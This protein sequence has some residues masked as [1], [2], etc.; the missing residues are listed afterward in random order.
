MNNLD[1]TKANLRR[2]AIPQT[3]DTAGM[4]RLRAATLRMSKA[5]AE[6]LLAEETG[7][8]KYDY[9]ALGI[10]HHPAETN[11]Q[12]EH[13]SIRATLVV[14]GIAVACLLGALAAMG[15]IGR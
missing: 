3:D 11:E 5:E 1:L 6:R 9:R 4:Q 14:V 15:I 7:A 12:L 8:N 2:R 13:T 10:H